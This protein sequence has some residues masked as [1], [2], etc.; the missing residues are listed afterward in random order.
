M[1]AIRISKTHH[2]SHRKA[3]E[4]AE[5]VAKD[6]HRRFGLDWE[7]DGD[8][9]DFSRA[10]LSG[11]LHVLQDEVRLDCQLGFVMSMFKPALEEAVHTEFDKYFGKPKRA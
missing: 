9:V 3:R 5:Q 10:G 6:L 1:A 8:C 4:A 11:K 7:W 2:L